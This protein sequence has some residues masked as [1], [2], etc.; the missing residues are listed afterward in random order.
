[1][2]TFGHTRLGFAPNSQNDLNLLQ[3][4]TLKKIPNLINFSP[5]WLKSSKND[6]YKENFKILLIFIK[7]Y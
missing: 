4:M 7:I 6:E 3:M 1:M 5:K 2:A